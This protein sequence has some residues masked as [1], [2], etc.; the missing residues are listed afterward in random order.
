MNA[1]AALIV[2]PLA[3]GRNRAGLRLAEMLEGTRGTQVVLLDRFA[4]LEPELRRLTREGVEAL[5]ISSGDGTIQ[6]I[7]TWLHERSG[8]PLEKMPV[9]AL[10]PHGSTNMT[11]ADIGFAHRSP[12]AQRDAMQF[13]AWRRRGAVVSRPTVRLLDPD[14][15]E[16]QHGMF[17]G[18]GVLAEAT[19]FCQQRFNSKGVR[20]QWGPLLTMLKVGG[21][22]LLR[23]AD[24]QDERRVDR[25]HRMRVLADGEEVASGWQTALLITTL[26][27]LVLGARPFWGDCGDEGEEAMRLSVF[28]HPPP[29][30][31]RWLPVVLYGGERR[32]LPPGMTSRCARRVELEIE[33]RLVL[34]GEKVPA[35]KGGRLLVEKGASLSYLRG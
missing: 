29:F 33:Q 22:A 35:P 5:F 24:P 8:L 31:P 32:R 6:F 21:Q 2:N 11:A 19:L 16:A 18:G 20:G 30:L 3:G 25:P 13:A 26:R 28:G 27:R 12:R 7:Q 1:R 23:P 14:G 34:D 17:L 10:L 4:R 15:G 9:L